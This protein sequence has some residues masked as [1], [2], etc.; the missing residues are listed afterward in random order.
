[1][2]IWQKPIS[3]ALLESIHVGTAVEHLGIEFVEVGDD[4]IRARL[5]VERRT[6]QPFGILHGGVSMVLAEALGSCGA[7]YA[8][9]EGRRSVGLDIN[10]NHVRAVPI[11]G[12][13]TGTAKP[14]H[15]GRTTQVWQID[16]ADEAGRTTCVSRITMAMLEA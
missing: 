2:N 16:M 9:P 3:V 13:V 4:F 1:L 8:S 10:A 14:V 6:Q 7:H 15:I 5:K 11:G 12:V